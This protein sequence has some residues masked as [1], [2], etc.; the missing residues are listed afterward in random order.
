MEYLYYSLLVGSSNA[1]N[2]TDGLDGLAGGLSA[3]SFLAFGL[4]AMGSWWI[5]GNS[6]MG[7]FCFIFGR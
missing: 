2:L 6:D 3:I 4:I 7:I 1:V 5:E